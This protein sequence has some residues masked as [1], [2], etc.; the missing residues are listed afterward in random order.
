MLKIQAIARIEYGIGQPSFAFTI[1]NAQMGC[2]QWFP[3]NLAGSEQGMNRE[4]G[5]DAAGVKKNNLNPPLFVQ[6]NTYSFTNRS[7]P[8][9]FGE[10]EVLPGSGSG[11]AT[12]CDSSHTRAQRPGKLTACSSPRRG[13][14]QGGLS[15]GVVKL[16]VPDGQKKYCTA[17]G[18]DL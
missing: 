18:C 5:V 11:M 12:G 17:S 14:V 3:P 7:S 2:F 13:H 16:L 15:L 10:E 1:W 8:Y 4:L 9:S 6:T